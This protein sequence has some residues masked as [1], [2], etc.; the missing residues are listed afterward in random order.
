MT[1]FDYRSNAL[2]DLVFLNRSSGLKQLALNMGN[3]LR[4]N[5][6]NEVRLPNR[7]H[8]CHGRFGQPHGGHNEG[9]TRTV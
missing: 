4:Y 6:I 2:A 8:Y 9:L 1:N 3:H 5:Y 7:L